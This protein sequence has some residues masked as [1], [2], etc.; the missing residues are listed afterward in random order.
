VALKANLFG[1]DM[2]KF[3]VGGQYQL[4]ENALIK[5]R[6]CDNGLVGLV[7]QFKI[8]ENVEGNYYFGLDAS[9]PLKGD[10]KIGIS[11]KFKG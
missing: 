7:Y 8:T 9:S 2:K 11:W 1:K 4:N 3:T 6:I 5:A 10:H